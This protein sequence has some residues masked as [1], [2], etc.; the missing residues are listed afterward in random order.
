MRIDLHRAEV[1][2][3]RHARIRL[4]RINPDTEAAIDTVKNVLKTGKLVRK[5]EKNG[6]I[7]TVVKKYKGREITVEFAYRAGHI[8]VVTVKVR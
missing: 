7:S 3:S 1:R 8:D 2:F 6:N 5:G 4:K